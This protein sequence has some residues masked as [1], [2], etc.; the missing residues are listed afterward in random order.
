MTITKIP[1]KTKIVATIGPA[2]SDEKILDRMIEAGM[3]VARLNFSHGTYEHHLDIIRKIRAISKSKD[4]PTAILQ[5]LCGPKIRLGDL[6]KPVELKQDETI[7]LS[8]DMEKTPDAQLY[9]DFKPMVEI[10]KKGETLLLDDGNIEMEVTEIH[11]YFLVCKVKA[12]GTAKSKKGINLPESDM[13]IP[14]FTEKDKK[15]LEFGLKNGVDFVAMSFVD[16]A[17]NIVPVKEMMKEYSHEIPVIAKIERPVA[18]KNIDS[19][20]DAFD[21]IMIARGDLGVE[22][23]LEEV[24]IIQ[25]RLIR[26]ANQKNKFVITA[27]QML[28]SMIDNPRPTRAEASDVSN[29]ILDGSDAIMLSG[30]TAVGQY[31]VK[32]I[33]VMQRIAETTESS[34]LYRCGANIHKEKIDHTEAISESAVR[35]ARELNARY[36]IVYSYTGNTAIRISKYR[37]DCPVFA[38]SSRP[39]VV[40]RMAAYRGIYPFYIQFS[41]NTD[42]MIRLGEELL[43]S[44]ELIEPG[45]L[46]ITVS[47]MAPMK[48]ATN[49]LKVER[50]GHR[51]PFRE[52]VPGLPKASKKLLNK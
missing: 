38:I 6:P 12:P 52:Q 43:E 4:K 23:P 20:M 26:M 22:M 50:F 34:S 39:E 44:K 7:K 28:E 51:E 30:E 5:D 49:M 33:E 32:T 11:P 37:P 13:P 48:G 40:T 24:P 3:S 21:G 2:S 29:A 25:K 46:V 19:I 47:G 36:I 18:I 42:E 41:T 16:S 17:E 8:I 9:T 15:D 35:I 31:P 27:T 10:V 45:D 1:V 14:V